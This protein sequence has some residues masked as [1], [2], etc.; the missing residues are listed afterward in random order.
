MPA[1][2]TPWFRLAAL[3]AALAAGDGG[4]RA[5]E[6]PAAYEYVMHALGAVD[7]AGLNDAGLMVLN[8]DVGG[9]LPRSYLAVLNAQNERE[10]TLIPGI[11]G[12]NGS[13]TAR[14][15]SESGVVVGIAHGGDVLEERGT[16]TGIHP[17]F[18]GFRH[19]GAT[20]DLGYLDILQIGIPLEQDYFA[21]EAFD[22]SSTGRIV[23]QLR[24]APVATQYRAVVWA[25]GAAPPVLL[26]AA[27][28][29]ATAVDTS[30][31]IVGWTRSGILQ[32]ATLWHEGGEHDID[33]AGS[34]VATPHDMNDQGQV[35]G[36]RLVISP[37]N[38]P[39]DHAFLT[40][41]NGTAVASNVDL[42]VLPT[43]RDSRALAINEAGLVVGSSS[44]EY[45]PGLFEERA[46]RWKDGVI[47][48]LNALVDPDS[49]GVPRDEQTTIPLPWRVTR[50][51]DVNASGAILCRG[52]VD[53]GSGPELR[54]FLLKPKVAGLDV[55]PRALSFGD[56]PAGDKAER[57]VLVSNGTSETLKIRLA[58]PAKPFTL[59][60]PAPFA[61]A[62][63]AS[64]IVRVRLAMKDDGDASGA[65]VVSSD[66]GSNVT[67]T[68]SARSVAPIRITPA[69]LDFG[70]VWGTATD[71]V[72][73]TNLSQ[74]RIRVALSGVK[75]PFAL[76]G[77]A[78]FVLEP[79]ST[80][81][82]V[83]DL[84]PTAPGEVRGSLVVTPST[85]RAAST[86]VALAGAGA[87]TIRVRTV[88]GEVTHREGVGD[89][90]FLEE[91]AEL[92]ENREIATG[93]ESGVELEFPDGGTMTL[94]ELTQI[95]T[96]T[97]F[98]APDRRDV[99]IQLEVGEV[100]AKITPRKTLETNFEVATPI[101]TAGVRGTE[102]ETVH[103]EA[104]GTTTV[105]VTE[106]KV[107]VAPTGA[108][109]KK[110]LVRAGR[111]VRVT[112]DSVSKPER[113]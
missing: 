64:K 7:A 75:K 52:T 16:G 67:A 100:K 58:K 38:P 44:V 84:E 10:T 113:L 41:L 72:T 26:S 11:P 18:R 93:V 2:R 48:D 76:R 109:L 63:G 46:A 78:S 36:A 110:V 50:A 39:Y 79:E 70:K 87:S 98:F 68:L 73:L 57:E 27:Q 14:R 45:S 19:G 12:S 65:L 24:T 66:R 112:A 99:V 22:I 103:D 17:F 85:A 32:R 55:Q 91:G 3:A 20:T 60:A 1:P 13:V 31:R 34:F 71:E 56:V 35:V 104:T 62:P 107:E 25:A 74:K 49:P 42:G 92:D 23:G 47:A 81:D 86:T 96:A 8:T 90:E 54:S 40:Q 83:L 80:R 111:Q 101:A 69:P 21:S 94:R 82:V 9:A 95:R 30:G 108:G 59:A 6:P 33:V 5:D 102:F 89:F 15:I 29:C 51:V 53:A 105:R 4:L 28:S 43:G 97:L 77:P 88:T 37:P 106:G 61:L